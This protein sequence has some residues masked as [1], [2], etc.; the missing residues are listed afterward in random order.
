MHVQERHDYLF[1]L[2][3]TLKCCYNIINKYAK[4]FKNQCL[5]NINNHNN[6]NI[7]TNNE[8]YF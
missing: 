7:K 8:N 2:N 1:I 4:Y 6:I 3:K 5:K